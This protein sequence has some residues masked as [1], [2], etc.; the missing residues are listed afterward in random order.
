MVPI[1]ANAQVPIN[2]NK[3]T[4]AFTMHYYLNREQFGK[5]P[6]LAAPTTMS[7]ILTDGSGRS[8]GYYANQKAK[9]TRKPQTKREYLLKEEAKHFPHA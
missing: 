7:L 3:P 6:I 2:M 8:C 9:R 1:R 4:D 5:R